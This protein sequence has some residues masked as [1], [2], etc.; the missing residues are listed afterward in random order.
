VLLLTV[1]CFSWFVNEFKTSFPPY[2]W[3]VHSRHFQAQHHGVTAH[4][5]LLLYNVLLVVTLLRR[6][7][8]LTD[9]R[10][11]TSRGPTTVFEAIHIHHHVTSS[12]TATNFLNGARTDHAYLYRVSPTPY[13][14]LVL[15]LSYFLLRVQR[16]LLTHS[17]IGTTVQRLRNRSKGN[18]HRTY[19]SS[20]YGPAT[21]PRP[22]E[23]LANEA[24]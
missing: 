19:L 18:T 15:P 17:S 2:H 9:H 7:Y 8:S 21:T 11:L 20:K 1:H 24:C 13:K 12:H 16:G 6:I 4:R 3:P 10:G 22:V 14:H 23:P 5:Q